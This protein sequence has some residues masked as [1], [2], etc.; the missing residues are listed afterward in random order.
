MAEDVSAV[1][2]MTDIVE[3]N[4]KEEAAEGES[5]QGYFCSVP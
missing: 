4:D 5:G 1:E 3:D 2:D